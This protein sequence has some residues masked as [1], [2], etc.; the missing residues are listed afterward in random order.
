MYTPPHYEAGEAQAIAL[1]RQFPF[2][3][4]IT[5][6]PEGLFTTHLPLILQEGPLVLRGHMARANQHW[7]FLED[8][9]STVVFSGPHAYISPAWYE[10]APAVPTWNYAAVHVRG[11]AQIGA[12]AVAILKESV[13]LF[14]TAGWVMDL[15]PAYDAKMRAGI[16]AFELPVAAME[17]KLKLS[18]NRSAEDR[19]GVIA[20]LQAS[21]NLYDREL[22]ALMAKECDG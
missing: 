6:G 18:Q 12:D 11:R 15:P 21:P 1:I 16:V 14:D 8:A 9:D 13:A 22:A 19:A 17:A 5:P 10:T 7:R 4:L 3:V 20:A 2:A